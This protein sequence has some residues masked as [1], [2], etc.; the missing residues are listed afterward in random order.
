MPSADGEPL[1]VKPVRDD[2][3]ALGASSWCNAVA[4]R[5]CRA[6]AREERND[7]FRVLARRSGMLADICQSFYERATPVH[8]RS[9]RTRVSQVPF[10]SVGEAELAP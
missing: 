3:V 6:T 2:R 4:G 8:A 5:N 10:R 7:A 1:R 9:P